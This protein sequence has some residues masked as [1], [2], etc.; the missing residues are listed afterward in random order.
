M[1]I[2]QGESDLGFEC[3]RRAYL[4]NTLRHGELGVMKTIIHRPVKPRQYENEMTQFES[5]VPSV[6]GTLGTMMDLENQ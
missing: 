3:G 1:D 4:T 6:R 5:A 2:N